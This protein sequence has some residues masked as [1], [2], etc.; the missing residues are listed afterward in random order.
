VDP[1]R[2]NRDID[3]LAAEVIHHLAKLPNAVVKVTVEI[4]ADAPGGVPDDVVR[5]VS[6]NCRTLKFTDHGFE[7][8]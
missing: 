3:A 7:K 1:Q 4:Q 6:E 5:T 8:E 2:I